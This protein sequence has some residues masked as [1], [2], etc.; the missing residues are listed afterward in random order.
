MTGDVG[1]WASQTC[2]ERIEQAWKRT[3]PTLALRPMQLAVE[4]GDF[5]KPRDV[6]WLDAT[7]D[8][9]LSLKNTDEGTSQAALT[10]LLWSSV[11]I[12]MDKTVVNMDVFRDLALKPKVSGE[13]KVKFEEPHKT[14]KSKRFF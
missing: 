14:S 9:K 7:P 13:T 12:P 3:P 5:I 2:Q 1:K 10:T 6:C 4:L 11:D 8:A